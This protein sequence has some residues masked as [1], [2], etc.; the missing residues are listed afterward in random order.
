MSMV[1]EFKAFVMRGNVVD[2][3][4]GVIIGGAFG[5]IVGSVI[6]DIIMPVVAKITGGGVDFSNL[7]YPLSDKIQKVGDQWP[8]LVEAKK[9]GPALAYGNFITI[10][11]NFAILA[12][13]IFLMIK[14]MNAAKKKEEAAP[15]PAPAPNPQ[16]VLLKEIRDLLKA[17]R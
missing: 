17:G 14:A 1:Q 9:L 15:A 5:K 4:V 3:A 6:D 8:S 16:E 11:I 2:L 12:F 13:I 7:Y 10:A